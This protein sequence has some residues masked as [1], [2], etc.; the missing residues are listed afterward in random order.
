MNFE[1]EWH[2]I[3]ENLGGESE[4]REMAREQGFL[5]WRHG[6]FNQSLVST[7]FGWISTK[8]SGSESLYRRLFC[9]C[10]ET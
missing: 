9:V 8:S 6:S 5:G 3:L 4:I 7:K 2:E 10:R 1:T